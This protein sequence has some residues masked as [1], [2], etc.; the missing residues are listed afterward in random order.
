MG[1]LVDLE[2]WRRA[3]RLC[4]IL[5]DRFGADFFVKD[6]ASVVL[7]EGRLARAGDLAV[8]WIGRRSGRVV[9]DVFAARI[10][11]MVRDLVVEQLVAGGVRFR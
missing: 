10:H 7:D 3:L 9:D 4:P 5:V 8:E 6:A 11:K 1:D 2:H